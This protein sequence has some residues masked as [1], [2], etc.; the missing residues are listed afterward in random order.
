MMTIYIKRFQNPFA[1]MVITHD[2]DWSSVSEASRTVDFVHYPFMFHPFQY[3][4][5]PHESVENILAFRD[6]SQENGQ[7]VYN[8]TLS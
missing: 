6:I 2:N 5:N 1:K 7:I 4:Y 3:N 8:V